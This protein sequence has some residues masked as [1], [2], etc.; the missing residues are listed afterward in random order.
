[1]QLFVRFFL[2]LALLLQSVAAAPAA[3]APVPKMSDA[4]LRELG[5]HIRDAGVT[6]EELETDF[7]AALIKIAKHHPDT[8]MML[9]GQLHAIE[10]L[11]AQVQTLEGEQRKQAIA[12]MNEPVK[13]LQQLFLDAYDKAAGLSGCVIAIIV[14]SILVA[15]GIIVGIVVCCVCKNKK[16]QQHQVVVAEP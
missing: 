13:P 1:M 4:Q 7:V 14:I 8:R 3:Q 10:Q 16:K 15:V 6:R 11:H 12:M 2:P 5:Q 9:G